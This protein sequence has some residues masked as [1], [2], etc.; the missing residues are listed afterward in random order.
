MDYD[1]VKQL[2]QINSRIHG[3]SHESVQLQIRYHCGRFTSAELA[4][5]LGVLHHGIVE[6]PRADLKSIW[7]VGILL[8]WHQRIG[9]GKTAVEL[10]LEEL[11]S[12]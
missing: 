5:E 4:L 7:L 1:L 12:H 11:L 6:E 3:P 2:E 8:V 10:G 9:H